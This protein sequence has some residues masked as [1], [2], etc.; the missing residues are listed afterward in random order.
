M[1]YHDLWNVSFLKVHA[2]VGLFG[3]ILAGHPYLQALT[4]QR[5][6]QL[7]HTMWTIVIYCPNFCGWYATIMSKDVQGHVAGLRP[8]QITQGFRIQLWQAKPLTQK[9]SLESESQSGWPRRQKGSRI[10]AEI[11]MIL[12]PEKN[13]IFI[14]MNLHI[15]AIR[16]SSSFRLEESKSQKRKDAKSAELWPVCN[17]SPSDLSPFPG[18]GHGQAPRS[19]CRCWRPAVIASHR[20]GVSCVSWCFM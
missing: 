17:S 11:L 14:H 2:R 9:V 13:R 15:T 5:G 4:A 16:Y 6:K 1:W 18:E 12:W 3:A 8:K 19:Y 10:T 7:M 20:I